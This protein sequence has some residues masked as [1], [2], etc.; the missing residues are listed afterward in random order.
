MS[1]PMR[2]LSGMIDDVRLETS[3]VNGIT[4]RM[5]T[6][7]RR[8]TGSTGQAPTPLN[9]AGAGEGAT[10]KSEPPLMVQLTLEIEGLKRATSELFDEINFLESISET[11]APSTEAKAT[12]AR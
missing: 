8:L 1:G 2:S 11:V 10:I 4:D 3:K 6:A 7:S 5:R 12:Y 9:P